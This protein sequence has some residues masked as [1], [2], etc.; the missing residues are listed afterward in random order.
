MTWCDLFFDALESV[1]TQSNVE[2]KMKIL[3]V[4]TTI[5]SKVA[6][7]RVFPIDRRNH[8]K[9]I[10]EDCQGNDSDKVSTQ[11]LQVQQNQLI[12]LQDHY[13]RYCNS[14]PVLG[15]N[16]SKYDINLIEEYL[17]TILVNERDI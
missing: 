14:L 7:I 5:R 9:D 2:E 10:E 12:E 15:T 1:A 11:V 8:R 13:V 17:T 16:S 3:Q 6:Q 4:E